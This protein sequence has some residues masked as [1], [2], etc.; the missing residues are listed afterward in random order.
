MNETV[1]GIFLLLG[2]IGLFLYGINFTSK[3]LEDAAGEILKIG[4][5]LLRPPERKLEIAGVVDC[6]R[7]EVAIEIGRKG[8]DAERLHAHR[9][10]AEARA[11]AERGGGIVRSA[12]NHMR[13]AGTAGIGADKIQFSHSITLPGQVHLL[14]SSRT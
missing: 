13:G 2:G 1:Y 12:E 6:E 9:R 14:S 7:G 5:R 8:F 3:S 4:K 11:G 10:R